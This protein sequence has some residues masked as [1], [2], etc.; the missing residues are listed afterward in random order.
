MDFNASNNFFLSLRTP[1]SKTG[2]EKPS[3][4]STGGL[5][6]RTHT[7]KLSSRKSRGSQRNDPVSFSTPCLHV[8]NPDILAERS[9]N[10]V[11]PAQP[12]SHPTK[13]SGIQSRR[14]LSPTPEVPDSAASIRQASRASNMGGIRRKLMSSFNDAP[15]AVKQR[16][17]F[18][19][20]NCKDLQH[21][22][23]DKSDIASK[24]TRVSTPDLIMRA[25]EVRIKCQPRI[26]SLVRPLTH[27]I[28]QL[29]ASRNQI[30]HNQPRFRA[31]PAVQRDRTGSAI[32]N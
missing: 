11:S 12:G 4:S 14:M 25:I 24:C 7:A 20:H 26:D 23:P 1:S 22:T 2:P 19:V 17:G 10:A 32:P 31:A 30:C 15:S 5:S 6:V 29:V 28:S 8:S 16:A 27:C 21:L 18:E 9:I 13:R 3:N